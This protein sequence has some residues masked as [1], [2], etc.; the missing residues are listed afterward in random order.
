MQKLLRLLVLPVFACATAACTVERDV[1]LYP[2][3][4]GTSGVAVLQGQ[5]VGHGHGHGTMDV[6]MPGGEHLQGEYSIVFDG[7][8]GFGSIFGTV[9]GSGGSASVSG[10]TADY[11]IAG[12]GEGEASL[13]GDRGTSMQCEFLNANFTGHGYGAC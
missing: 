2:L 1:H 8:A 7:S 4:E 3:D 5:I 13:A 6:S 9:Y 12:K 10:T 11:S